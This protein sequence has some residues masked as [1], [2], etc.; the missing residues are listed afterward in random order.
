MQQLL[1]FYM[2]YRNDWIW[3]WKRNSM[4]SVRCKETS[5]RE[6]SGRVFVWGFLV[7]L[8]SLFMFDWL[9]GCRFFC[10]FWFFFLKIISVIRIFCMVSKDILILEL[11]SFVGPDYTRGETKLKWLLGLLPCGYLY[12]L[13]SG[14][15]KVVLLILNQNS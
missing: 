10:L 8:V 4:K 9:L 15:V 12:N 7:V 1:Q 13:S 3:S 5:S 14:K 6:E 2:Y 11:G